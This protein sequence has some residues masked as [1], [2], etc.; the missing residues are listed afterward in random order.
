MR[1]STFTSSASS[2]RWSSPRSLLTLPTPPL[3]RPSSHSPLCRWPQRRSSSART[4]R[5]GRC[6]RLEGGEVGKASV[7]GKAAR[8]DAARARAAKVSAA[9]RGEP[10]TGSSGNEASATATRAAGGTQGPT[11]ESH[12]SHAP[13]MAPTTAGTSLRIPRCPTCPRRRPPRTGSTATWRGPCRARSP[14][15][16]SPSGTPPA[17]CL[18]ISRCAPPMSQTRRT[19]R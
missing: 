19:S 1:C 5:W 13:P 6:S 2:E 7:S 11:G 4:R 9:A 15:R 3:Q 12:A 14:R 18:P 8:A 17:T 10:P 16:R